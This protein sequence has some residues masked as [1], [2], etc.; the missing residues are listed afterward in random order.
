VVSRPVSPPPPKPSHTSL[1]L[2]PLLLLQL[3]PPSLFLLPNDAASG[4]GEG[5]AQSQGP[6]GRD[7]FGAQHDHHDAEKIFEG[8]LGDLCVGE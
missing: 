7:G 5:G 8:F 4:G 2:V 3:Q 6:G 1:S